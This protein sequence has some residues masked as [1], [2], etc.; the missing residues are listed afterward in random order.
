MT[1]YLPWG[2]QNRIDQDPPVKTP[3]QALKLKA[4]GSAEFGLAP[5]P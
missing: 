1:A 2:S 3:I 4:E 5:V